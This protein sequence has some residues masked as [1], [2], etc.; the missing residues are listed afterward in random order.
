MTSRSIPPEH[1]AETSPTS[2]TLDA[3]YT[4]NGPPTINPSLL[5]NSNARLDFFA[6]KSRGPLQGLSSKRLGHANDPEPPRQQIR[7]TDVLYR[8]RD[9][10]M[11]IWAL[12]K[13][14]RMLSTMFNEVDSQT[15]H[16]HDTRSHTVQGPSAAPRAR[17][18]DLAQLLKDERINGPSDRDPTVA[19]K[20][21]HIFKGPYI[22]IRDI[23]EKTRP[24]MVREYA[25]VTH[26]EN[27]DWPQFRSVANGKCPFV[28]EVDHNQRELDKEK[29]ARRLQKQQEMERCAAPK[30]RA[31]TEASKMQPPRPVDDTRALAEMNNSNRGSRA[32]SKPPTSMDKPLQ[33]YRTEIES[34]SRGL[35][36][37]FVSRA[38]AG[39]LYG[40]EPVASGLQ[41]SKV[42][43]AIRSQMISSTAAQPGAKAGTNKEIHGLQRKVLEKNSG[44]PASYGLNSSHRMTDL[45]FKEDMSTRRKAHEKIGHIEEDTEPSEPELRAKKV[46]SLRKAKVVQQRKHD[47]RDSKPGYCENCQDKFEDF[48]EV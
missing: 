3:V 19:S 39:R 46:E 40:G 47:K 9:L 28:G 37:A 31:A 33:K 45:S 2:T 48:E 43:S 13:L 15:S 36:N 16:G 20:D 29:E 4:H 41:P 34:S 32:T 22:Y 26:K 5:E 30:T 6:A 24:I 10:G 17:D 25:K 7:N 38:G 42:T 27:G 21:M 14:Y 8:A 12:E 23:D 18:A 1:E 44:G 11:K 35:H